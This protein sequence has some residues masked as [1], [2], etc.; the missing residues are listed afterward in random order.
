MSADR[1]NYLVYDG[2]CPFCSAYV[3]LLRLREAGSEIGL[4]NAREPHP[5]LQ[6]VRDRKISLDDGMALRLNGTWYHG[7]D[8]IHALALMSTRSGFF[9][10]L[11][12]AMF[13]SR[14]L[15]AIL[16]PALRAGR[17]GAIRILGYPKLDG[18][19]PVAQRTPQQG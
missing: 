7:A 11:N 17:N 3:K 13:R 15:S 10:R 2:A 4:V 14:T 16:Y 1:T 18:T 6:D 9:N 19:L 12:A 5:I 8:C